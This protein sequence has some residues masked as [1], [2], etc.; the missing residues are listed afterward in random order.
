MV[1]AGDLFV[2]LTVLLETEQVLRNS[3]GIYGQALQIALVALAR[4]PRIVMELPARAA[5]ALDWLGAG[6]DFADALHLAG[7]WECDE[8]VTFDKDFARQAMRLPGMKMR[9]LQRQQ[10]CSFLKKRTKKL[11]VL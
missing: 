1:N 2:S 4:L 7:A 3:Y 6:M 8:V 9:L 5:L 11:L 10:D